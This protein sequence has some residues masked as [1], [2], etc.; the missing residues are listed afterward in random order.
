MKRYEV[1]FWN[2]TN[3]NGYRSS[4]FFSATT[5]KAAKEEAEKY[6]KKTGLQMRIIAIM[7]CAFNIK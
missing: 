5:R 2:G 6:I 1:I 4:L 3:E 7:D